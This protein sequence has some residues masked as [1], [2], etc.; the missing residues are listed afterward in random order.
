[1]RCSAIVPST[2]SI[3]ALDPSTGEVGVAVAS[4]FL[5][6]GAVVPWARAGAGAVATQAW[7]NLGYGP[8]GLDLLARGHSAEDVVRLLTEPDPQ[9]DHRQVGVVDCRGNAAAWTGRECLAW[10]GHRTGRGYT[11]QG[12]IL[13]GAAVVDRMAEA[14]EGSTGPLPE[15]LLAALEA[16]QAAGGDSR[17]QQSAALYVAKEKGSYGGYLDRYID[18]RVDDHPTPLVEL[19]TL[20]ELHR[21]YFGTTDPARLTPLTGAVAREVQQILRRLGYYRG[22]ITGVY[23]DATREA[24]RRFCAIENFEERW[25]EDDLVDGEILQFMR[26]RFGAPADPQ[27]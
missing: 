4:K 24:F 1:M 16:G 6:V 26:R 23:D 11:C 10:A 9:R 13:A 12:N 8:Q 15:R 7:A 17:G 27:R 5:A 3:V 22:E 25:R 14:F 19:R 21:L 2:F 18:L 20:L